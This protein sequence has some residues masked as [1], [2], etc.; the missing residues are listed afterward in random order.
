MD[1][2]FI[3]LIIFKRSFDDNEFIL[4]TKVILSFVFEDNYFFNL[5][6]DIIKYKKIPH[7]FHVFFDFVKSY[8]NHII[9][10]PSLKF[11]KNIK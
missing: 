2:L 4:S 9:Y 8:Y 10:F 3:L 11:K 7:L 6:I 5:N 1:I